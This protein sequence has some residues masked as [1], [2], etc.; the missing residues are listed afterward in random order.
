MK[1]GIDARMYGSESTTGLGVYV[2]SLTDKLFSIDQKNKYFLFMNEP[3]FSKFQ[4]PSQNVK[5]IKVDIPWYSYTEQ[6][7]F[8]KILLSQKLDLVHF[9]HFNVPILYP[10]KFITTI[11]DI[12]PKF[13]PGPKVKKSLTRKIAYQT[14]FRNGL[15]RAKKIITISEYTTKN[16]VNFFNADKSKIV[17]I[18]NGF[19]EKISEVKDEELIKNFKAKN[20]ITKPFIFYVGVWRDH[21]NLPGLIKAFNILRQDFKQDYQLVLAGKQDGRYPE[22]LAT[23]NN[24]PFKSDIILPGYVADEDLPLF[25]SA[26]ELFVLPSFAEGFGLVSLESMA[27]NTPAISSKTTSLPEILEDAS[28]YFDPYDPHDMAKVFMSVIGDRE[29]YKSLQSLGLDQI[30]KYSWDKC[31]QQTL[32]IYQS[33]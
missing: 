2:K 28:L 25:Y 26:A 1:I 23:I 27:C 8:P 22:I 33:V 24:S 31:A 13:F 32:A 30:K 19:N 12:T 5:K 4:P 15:A 17:I 18:Y 16:L 3:G 6:L 20:N 21:K 11:H 9:P 7:K 14:V 29:K 10:K